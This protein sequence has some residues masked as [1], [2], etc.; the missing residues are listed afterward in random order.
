MMQSRANPSNFV[1]RLSR[2][3]LLLLVNTAFESGNYRFLRQSALAWLTSYPGDLEVNLFLARSLMAEGRTPQCIPMLEKLCRLDPEYE[4]AYAALAEANQQGTNVAKVTALAGLHVVSKKGLPVMNLPEWAEVLRAGRAALADGQ[5]DEAETL[6]AQVLSTEPDMPL[7][8]I[9]HTQVTRARGDA[10]TVVNLASAYHTRWPDCLQIALLLAEA[11]LETGDEASAVSLLHRCVV[12]DAAAQVA[13]RLWG[14]DFA[15]RPLWPAPMEIAYDIQIP[16]EI[17]ARLGWNL[18]SAGSTVEPD[19]FRIVEDPQFT[20]EDMLFIPR[21]RVEMPSEN[22]PVLPFIEALLTREETQGP[23]DEIIEGGIEDAG[24][25]QDVSTVKAEM[26]VTQAELTEIQALPKYAK[27]ALNDTLKSVQDEFEKVAKRLKKPGAGRAD[28][29]YP[30][31]VIF[32]TE[33]GMVKQYGINTL[34]VLDKELQ[35][36]SQQIAKKPG[37]DAL[38]FYPD[39]AACTEKYGLKPVESIDP[40]KLKLSL[41]DLDRALGK[42]GEMIAAVLIVGGSEVV[43]FHHL[44]NPTDDMDALIASDNPYATLDSNYFVQDWPV[45][46]LPGESGPDAGL[47][48]E[49]IRQ[50]TRSHTRDGQGKGRTVSADFWRRLQ[51]FLAMRAMGGKKANF[52]YTAA[53]WQRSSVAVFRPIGEAQTLLASPPQSS[54]SLQRG[55]LNG[56]SLGYYNLH[57]LEDAPEWYGQRDVTDPTPGPDYPVAITPRDISGKSH[58]PQIV[59]SEACYGAHV[60]GKNAD[61]SIALKFLSQGTQAMIGSSAA[62]YGSVSLPLIGADLLGNYFWKNLKA[63]NMVGAALMQAKVDLV[64]EMMHRQ[65]FLDGEDQK[66]LLSFILYGDPLTGTALTSQHQK[67]A[68]RSHLHPA[69]KT[70]CDRQEEGRPSIPVP[71]EVLKQVKAVVSEYLPGLESAELSVHHQYDDCDGKGHHCPTSQI[72]AKSAHNGGS[73]RTV[74]TIHKEVKI[75]PHKQQ[76]YARVTLDQKGKVVKLALSR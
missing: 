75:G 41:A 46:R 42:K 74:V 24:E 13:A 39:S 68:L 70:I 62:A 67:T 19:V 40:W 12:H 16:A 64:R 15:Y 7:A 52:G 11:Q 47:L 28:G 35:K 32:S 58:S 5:L 17:A 65:G 18:L 49:Q 9:L 71:G 33:E 61:Q 45:G 43:P 14:E 59:F 63:G 53:V 30:V 60:E 4:A 1:S 73:G 3:K 22:E 50:I 21:Q 27:P 76:Q 57:G 44:P 10:M 2:E 55:K 51:V 36:L 66:T 34:D 26:P 25:A 38:V 54:G 72:G 56:T 31:Y 48:L 69:V 23:E 20:E 8:G 29:R 37:W 6:V